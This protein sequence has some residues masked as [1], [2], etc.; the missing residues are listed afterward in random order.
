MNLGLSFS[1]QWQWPRTN[2]LLFFNCTVGI[3]M[4]GV[5]KT[6]VLRRRRTRWFC[7]RKGH[8]STKNR[9]V[10][11]VCPPKSYAR[12]RDWFKEISFPAGRHCRVEC[13]NNFM[14]QTRSGE[15]SESNSN[16]GGAATG[17]SNDGHQRVSTVF[18]TLGHPVLR[19][20]DPKKIAKFL[21]ERK[22]YEIEVQEKA[23]EVPSMKAASYDVPTDQAL[24]ENMFF[25][26][27]DE[28]APDKDFDNLTSGDIEKFI[29]GIVK[30]DKDEE[31][32]TVI[33]AAV[34]GLRMPMDIEDST[35]RMLEFIN[36]AFKRL[37]GVGY[38]DFKDTNPKKTIKLMH[39]KVYPF[40]LKAMMQQHL[41]YQ[42]GPKTNLKVYIKLLCKE[43]KVV[44]RSKPKTSPAAE[45]APS[46]AARSAD[47]GDNRKPASGKSAGGSSRVPGGTQS[48]KFVPLCLNEKHQLKG[49]RH[50]MP[51]CDI[52]SKDITSKE[53]GDRLVE[54]YKAN[55][56]K[57]SKKVTWESQEA[58][59][60][61]M[62]NKS[63]SIKCYFRW[64]RKPEWSVRMEDRI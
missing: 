29:K 46:K 20:V 10:E 28:I 23:K 62:D 6:F 63:T 25:C 44:E 32:P 36:D 2:C 22:R 40:A 3:S 24:L 19:S 56:R 21:R 55:K 58:G 57:E 9:A 30:H 49:I 38:S 51:D 17:D 41:E 37:E 64:I 43:A 7:K 8:R 45:K 35:A 47:K 59:T 11:R 61:N 60:F 53:E 31:M 42:D 1:A 13:G 33:E 18:E 34:K 52:T 5:P 12:K 50:Y 27:F 39:E 4:K 15:P 54:Q 48:G 26:A 16:S 14:V